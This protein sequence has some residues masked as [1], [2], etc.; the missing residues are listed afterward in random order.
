MTV[1]Q[2]TRDR[3]VHQAGALSTSAVRRLEA[4]LDWYRALSGGQLGTVGKVTVPTT[5]VWSDGDPAF[6]RPAALF[7]GFLF[8]HIG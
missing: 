6:G 5:Y 7:E 4:D 2:K 1:S 8:G 3:V